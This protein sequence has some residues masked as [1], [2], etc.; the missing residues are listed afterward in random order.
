MN[1]HTH[2]HNSI[3]HAQLHIMILEENIGLGIILLVLPNPPVSRVADWWLWWT[4][5]ASRLQ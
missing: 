4:V 3:I 5:A 2:N 1:I